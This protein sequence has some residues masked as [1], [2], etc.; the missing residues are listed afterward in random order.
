MLKVT[1]LLFSLL[2]GFPLFAGK[3][4]ITSS[5]PKVSKIDPF[6]L[7]RNLVKDY[8]WQEELRRQKN[9]NW[10]DSLPLGCLHLQDPGYFLCNNRY[11]R[12][13]QYKE[14]RLYI[15]IRPN[16]SFDDN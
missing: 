1:I 7:K 11:Y 12:S 6:E 3:I 16:N 10:L 5:S 8:Q 14:H 2:W 15:E 4:T 13:Y 9:L